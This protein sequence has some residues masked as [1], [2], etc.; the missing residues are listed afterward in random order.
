MITIANV[1]LLIEAQLI[2]AALEGHGIAAHIPDELTVQAASPYAL[3]IG[4]IR[5]QVEDEDE[6]AAREILASTPPA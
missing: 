6:A 3:V 2:R 4:G 1:T 5:V